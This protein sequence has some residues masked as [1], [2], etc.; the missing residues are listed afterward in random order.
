MN[1]WRLLML[2][3]YGWQ[4]GT[5][6][7]V[8]TF[9]A[10]L[11]LICILV[12]LLTYPHGINWTPAA[13]ANWTRGCGHGLSLL[14]IVLWAVL[15]PNNL[16]L[17]HA[18]RH[19][20]MPR[21]Q[22]ESRFSLCLYALLSIGLPAALLG[23]AGGPAA[24]IAVELLLAAGLGM[25]YAVLPRY[26]AILVLF[27]PQLHGALWRW[28]ALPG[29][30]QPGF[31]LPSVLLA[32]GLWAI[33]GW[34]WHRVSRDE[35]VMNGLH[36]PMLWTFRLA[37]L[38]RGGNLYPG[39][40]DAGGQSRQLPD[41]L[42]PKV[43]L[44]GTGP[45]RVRQLIILLLGYSLLASLLVMQASGYGS[46]AHEHVSA[47][48]GI[49]TLLWIAPCFSAG[50]ALGIGRTLRLRWSRWDAELSLLA[51]LPGLGDPAQMKR[52][53]LR[54]S[55][56]PSMSVQ[57]LLLLASILLA[58][59]WHM[60]DGSDLLLLLIG[61]LAGIGLLLAS[62]LSVF[63]GTS[64]HAGHNT[65]LRVAGGIWFTLLIF[66][67]ASL[68]KTAPGTVMASLLAIGWTTFGMGLLWLG[69]RGWRGLQLRPHPFLV[70]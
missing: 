53:L 52:A 13:A 22:R 45:F 66:A 25:A 70:N 54:A 58:L 37:M 57:G 61:Q 16:L 6:L 32:V 3:W 69:Q 10:V 21:V 56:L 49:N 62:T 11:L 51:L 31:L 46:D 14:N 23:F 27:A 36:A 34:R 64:L 68:G 4:S 19:Q 43:D 35:A 2:P 20:R 7:V 63:G 26:I 1:P 17:T 9:S 40:A 30:T 44:R 48:G 12:V 39:I 50:L 38:R 8:A 29:D 65:A 67:A 60:A 47:F 41:W 18:A 15:L 24:V 55:L 5:R 42:R 59:W 33:V 28:L